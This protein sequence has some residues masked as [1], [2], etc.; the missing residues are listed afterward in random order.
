MKEKRLNTDIDWYLSLIG[1]VT[2]Q[3]QTHTHV[4]ALMFACAISHTLLFAYSQYVRSLSHLL[5]N[6]FLSFLT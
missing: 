6:N 3:L 5:Y 1:T 4:F 2:I